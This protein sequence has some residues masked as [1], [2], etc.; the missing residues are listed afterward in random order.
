LYHD[1]CLP[2]D[3]AGLRCTFDSHIRVLLWKKLAVN[4]VVNPL[5]AL[6]G[7]PNGALLDRI[8]GFTTDILPDLVRDDYD[9]YRHSEKG[10]DLQYTS[11]SEAAVEPEQE[12]RDEFQAWQDYV[13]E[14]IHA[15]A[16]HRSSML[17]DVQQQQPTLPDH[18]HRPQQT[19]ID[20]LNGFVVRQARALGLPCD[21]NERLVQSVQKLTNVSAHDFMYS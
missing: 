6:Y 7:C 1:S 12:E 21:K 19:E 17:Q 3:R 8:D 2:L 18:L 20:A 4:C 10:K 15:T 9:V 5:T 14:V 16:A 13:L 11:S